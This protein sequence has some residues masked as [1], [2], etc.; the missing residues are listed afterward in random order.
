MQE[1]I[2]S[3]LK[4]FFFQITKPPY[5]KCIIPGKRNFKIKKSPDSIIV[6]YKAR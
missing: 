6:F 1:K 2:I 3:Q 4:I 5:N